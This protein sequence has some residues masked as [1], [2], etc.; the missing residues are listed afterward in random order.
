MNLNV[1][2]TGCNVTLLRDVKF[3]ER[4]IET[5]DEIIGSSVVTQSYAK[6]FPQ[7]F[8]RRGFFV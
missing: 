1:K 3:P 5:F 6:K 2:Q 8:K 7:R 4:P